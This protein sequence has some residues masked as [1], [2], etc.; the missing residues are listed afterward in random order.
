MLWILTLFVKKLKRGMR[1]YKV[2]LKPNAQ[3]DIKDTIAWYDLQKKG[4]GKTFYTYVVKKIMQLQSFPFSAQTD[5]RMSEQQ[6]LRSFH[7]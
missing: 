6:W 7:F 2:V 1:N 5:I 4:L 3:A